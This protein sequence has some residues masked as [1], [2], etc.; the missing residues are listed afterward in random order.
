MPELWQRFEEESANLLVW[1]PYLAN[2]LIQQSSVWLAVSVACVA[3][4]DARSI[5]FQPAR[6]SERIAY[7]SFL[8]DELHI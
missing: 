7:S 1:H 8:G 2:L 5:L 3:E 4:G 6:G